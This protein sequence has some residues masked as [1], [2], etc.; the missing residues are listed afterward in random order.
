MCK[1]RA[2]TYE[3]V[4]GLWKGEILPNKRGNTT[5]IDRLDKVQN[6]ENR[7]RGFSIP[8][9]VWSS[10]VSQVSEVT[11]F[12]LFFTAFLDFYRSWID[13]SAVTGAGAAMCLLIVM[14]VIDVI[15]IVG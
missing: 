2:N 4:R 8:T 9:R 1:F 3:V 6:T 14:S 13:I 5:E 7:G 11:L 12:K 10:E 15:L